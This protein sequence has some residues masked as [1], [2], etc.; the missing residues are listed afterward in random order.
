MSPKSSVVFLQ[1]LA[2]GV[3]ALGLM[4][5]IGSVLQPRTVGFFGARVPSALVA[6]IVLAVGF[7]YWNRAARL[8]AKVLSGNVL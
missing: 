1:I 6:L 5:L 7:Y 2:G 3:I 8:K 4:G